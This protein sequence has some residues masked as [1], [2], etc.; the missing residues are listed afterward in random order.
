MGIGFSDEFVKFGE[1]NGMYIIDHCLV[2][3]S[4]LAAWFCV[5]K[6]G[7]AV[8]AEI[9]REEFTP[10][11]FQYAHEADTEAELY[12]NDYKIVIPGRTV[13]L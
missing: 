6:D 11:A 13:F 3:Y 9:L 2:W 4:Q 5:N 10:L 1:D 8:S 7:K 12:Y